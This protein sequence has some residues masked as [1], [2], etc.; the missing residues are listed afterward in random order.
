MFPFWSVDKVDYVQ[1]LGSIAAAFQQQIIT[2]PQGEVWIPLSMS[3]D[4]TGTII[5]ESFKMV[6]GVSNPSNVSRVHLAIGGSE[7][8]ITALET[9]TTTFTWAMLQPASSG[10]NFYTQCH[11]FN[12]AGAR[13][14]QLRLRFIRLLA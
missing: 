3:S 13:N 8:S 4:I 1:F 7:P 14:T 6:I 10:E 12:A 11:E 9:T 2:V 5:G